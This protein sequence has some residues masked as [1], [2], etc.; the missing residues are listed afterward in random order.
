MPSLIGPGRSSGL[1]RL[2]LTI[3]SARALLKN[4]GVEIVD[5]E[6]PVSTAVLAVADEIAAMRLAAA[7]ALAAPGSVLGNLTPASALVR[8]GQVI[9]EWYPAV[10]MGEY[11]GFHLKS[12]HGTIRSEYPVSYGRITDATIETLRKGG[13]ERT[14]RRDRPS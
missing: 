5:H 14:R 3:D 10:F 11:E 9:P 4:I 13:E 1:P 2:F 8:M 6:L 7:V 12:L